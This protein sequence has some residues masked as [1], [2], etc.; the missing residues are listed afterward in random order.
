M[1][2][3]VADETELANR[4]VRDDGLKFKQPVFQKPVRLPKKP[5][6]VACPIG[7]AY[8]YTAD[9]AVFSDRVPHYARAALLLP[10]GFRS[11][12]VAYLIVGHQAGGG[13]VSQEQAEYFSALL[14]G[15]REKESD[16]PAGTQ[17]AAATR[18]PVSD[19]H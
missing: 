16:Q 19:G 3:S 17:T 18:S 1:D 13:L 6:L 11:R 12:L 14:Q 9:R 7:T 10:S 4:L 15:I 8:V 5:E 2:A